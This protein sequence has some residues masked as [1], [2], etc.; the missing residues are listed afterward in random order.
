MN[1]V[2]NYVW[3]ALSCILLPY[4]YF[5]ARIYLYGQKNAP[6]GYRYPRISDLWVMLPGVVAFAVI[7]RVVLYFAT[8]LIR[9]WVK[10]QDDPELCAKYT[11]KSCESFVKLT[12]YLIL[13]S[14][15]NYILKETNWL[16]WYCGGKF[17]SFDALNENMP[18]TETPLYAYECFLMFL[19]L[20][21]YQLIDLLTSGLDRPDFNEM[22]C[23]HI[24]AVS[25]TLCAIYSNTLG[26]GILVAYI[27]ALSDIP[28]NTSRIFASMKYVTPMLVSYFMMLAGWIWLRIGCLGYILYRLWGRRFSAD[29]SRFD[30]FFTVECLFST[31]LYGLHI[32]WL[33]LI[34][35]M[36]L[37]Y[38]KTGATTDL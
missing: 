22:L 1:R 26:T 8:P 16:P 31:V 19:A 17:G 21:V 3:V 2:F 4:F 32:H 34:V 5:T 20:Y 24:C 12:F 28:V 27:H 36:I 38:K 6:Q 13:C 35:L 7:Q 29:L 18:F 30:P 37:H 14:W 33:R 11:K 25:C 10:S 15:T 23:H 9:K